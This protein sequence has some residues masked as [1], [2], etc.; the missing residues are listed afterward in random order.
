MSGNERS[1]RQLVS[2]P[3]NYTLTADWGKWVN[4][5]LDKRLKDGFGFGRWACEREGEAFTCH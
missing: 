3:N 5:Y 2:T 1:E 4:W